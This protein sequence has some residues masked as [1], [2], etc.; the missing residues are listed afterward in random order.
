[1]LNLFT[2]KSVEKL[3]QRKQV[4]KLI[5]AKTLLSPKFQKIENQEPRILRQPSFSFSP[6][7]SMLRNSAWLVQIPQTPTQH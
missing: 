7:I 2:I 6:P 3:S 1:M 5:K 4:E